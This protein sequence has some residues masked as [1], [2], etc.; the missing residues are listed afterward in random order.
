V[1]ATTLAC[2]GIKVR[3]AVSP[4]ANFTALHTFQVL[5]V[6]QSRTPSSGDTNDPMLVNSISNRALCSDLVQGFQARGYVIADSNPDFAV[7]YYASTREKLDVTDWDY[8]YA[9]QPYWWGGWGAGMEPMDQ[10]VTQYTQG[11]VVVDV[12][13]SKTKELLWRGS[14]VA[15]VSDN[16][17]EY[18]QELQKAVTAILDKFPRARQNS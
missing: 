4:D 7:A 1:L 10:T 8:G 3:T 2:S 17:K 16:Q 13:D 12:L 5:P 6:P 9:F 18:E 11:T 15:R 14:G